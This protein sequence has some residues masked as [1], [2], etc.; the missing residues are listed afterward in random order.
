MTDF[1]IN[2]FNIEFEQKQREQQYKPIIR[3]ETIQPKR[4]DQYTIGELL[5]EYKNSLLEIIDSLILFR[6]NNMNEFIDIFTKNNNL[7]TIGITILILSFGLW[8]F[9]NI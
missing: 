4:L 5:I 9:K 3:S 2:K 1:D 6:Y 8:F 7:L